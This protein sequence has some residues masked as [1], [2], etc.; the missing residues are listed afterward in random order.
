MITIID[1]DLG[2]LESIKNMFSKVGIEATITKDT[3]LISKGEK[4]ILPGVGSYEYG[5]SKLKGMP[6]F[7]VLESKIMKEKK[8]ILGI[9]LGA[10]LL[11]ESSEEGNSPTGL[12]WLK[13]KVVKFRPELMSEPLKIPQMGWNWVKSNKESKLAEGMNE[14]SRFYF[15]HS[16]HFAETEAANILFS[17]EYGY[18]FVSGI[19]KENILGV[20]FHPEKSH[21]FGFQLF[22]NFALNY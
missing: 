20:Q 3:E 12:G 17:S 11:F 16:Y 22:K 9:C 21:N 15:V 1:Y 5:I 8:P 7:D 13:G 6:Y 18:E 4:F 19:E 14:E 2:N 10:Q